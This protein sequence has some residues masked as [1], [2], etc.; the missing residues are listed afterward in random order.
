MIRTYC[1]IVFTS[2]SINNFA[3][4]SIIFYYSIVIYLLIKFRIQIERRKSEKKQPEFPNSVSGEVVAN[5]DRR[6]FLLLDLCN[7]LMVV[8]NEG[9]C[10]SK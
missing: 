10:T 3:V 2:W 1:F 6:C 8:R 9:N 5:V 7:K 4:K